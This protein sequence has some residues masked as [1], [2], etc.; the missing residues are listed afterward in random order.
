MLHVG[1]MHGDL[2][3]HHM[4]YLELEPTS[5]SLV[6][7]LVFEPEAA[8]EVDMSALP[9]GGGETLADFRDGRE[10]NALAEEEMLATM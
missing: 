4:V 7:T 6:S 3:K 8:Y 10:Y 2:E 1:A 5:S 9:L